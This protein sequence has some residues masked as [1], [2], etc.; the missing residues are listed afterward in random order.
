MKTLLFACS[1]VGTCLLVTLVALPQPPD[2]LW[3]RTFGG[4]N[5]EHGFSVLQ[6]YDGGYVLAGYTASF[7][8][9]SADMWLVK[10][11]AEGDSLWSRTYG[12][13][14]WDDCRCIQKTQ[15]GGYVLA[16]CSYSFGAGDYDFWLVKVDANGD[17]IWSRTFGGPGAERAY[18]VRQ[19]SD[20][21]YILGGGTESFGAGQEDVWLVKTDANGDSLWSRTFGGD[22]VEYCRSVQQTA[23]GGYILVGGTMSWGAGDWDFW[24]VKT[25]AD[26]DSL[27]SRTFGGSSF[28]SCSSI[29]QVADGYILIGTTG[30]YDFWMVKM[31]A[32]GDSLWSRRFGGPGC[33]RGYTSAPV[34]DGGW[35]L[36]GCSCSYGGGWYLHPEFWLLRTSA[37]GDSLWSRTFGGPDWDQCW[38]VQVT[39][40]GGYILGGVTLSFG[41]GNRDFWLVKTGVDPLPSELRTVSIPSHYSLQQNW[42]NPFNPST[43]IA[44]D[45]PQ[46][47]HVSLKVF[48]LLGREVA[49]LVDEKQSPGSYC[50]AFDGSGLP[51]GIYLYRI[52]AGDWTQTKKMV[53]LK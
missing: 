37:N 2:S 20:G 25:N 28:E 17:S 3:S 38:S 26:G 32:D 6:A 47:G 27:W 31:S 19:T 39:S 13:S 1:V 48:D 52:D 45:L 50:S 49:T 11:S 29:W 46:A 8:A 41:A 42:P 40:D 36:A 15:D 35:I 4:P 51:S 30:I 34:P 21:G 12:G 33:E 7:G 16:G 24:V 9:G 53:L 10:A 43:Q 14:S 5:D 22:S 23:D 18:S 44:Y